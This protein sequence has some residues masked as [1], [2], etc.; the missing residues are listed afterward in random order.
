MLLRAPPVA[1]VILFDFLAPSLCR[2]ARAA[3]TASA[4]SSSRS[5][6]RSRPHSRLILHRA[7]APRLNYDPLQGINPDVFTDVTE[8]LIEK[9]PVIHYQASEPEKKADVFNAILHRLNIS[10]RDGDA[11]NVLRHWRDMAD[12]DLLP[13][14]SSNN[15]RQVSQ[16]ISTLISPS[17]ERSL[18][19]GIEDVAI[20]TA[21]SHFTD[22]LV[23]AM[24]YH[25]KHND[26]EAVISL[27]DR[28]KSLMVEKG[29]WE[30]GNAEQEEEEAPGDILPSVDDTAFRGASI[31]LPARIKVLLAA[32]VACA[33]R[34]DFQGALTTSL[35]TDVRFQFHTNMEFLSQLD[36]DS[37]LREKVAGYIRK[38]SLAKR[39]SHPL[40]FNFHVSRLG[41][42]KRLQDLLSDIVEGI[43]GRNAFIA[44]HP[45]LITESKPVSMTQ[46]G[47]ASFL[48]GF[49]HCKRK[50]LA[51]E[52]WERLPA[53]GVPHDVSM[54]TALISACAETWDPSEALGYW[55]LMRSKGVQPNALTHRALIIAYF[56]SKQPR[57]AIAHFHDF[58]TQCTRRKFSSDDVL[59]VY[60]AVINGQLKY[61]R[62]EDAKGTLRKLKGNGVTPSVETFNAF[63]IHFAARNDLHGIT[64]IMDEMSAAGVQGD[65]LTYSTILSALLKAGRTD[66]LDLV[67]GI[68]ESQG[69]EPST[70]TYTAIIKKQME[71][72]DEENFRGAL[73]L[74]KKMESDPQIQPTAETYLTFLRGLHR[75][76]LFSNDKVNKVTELIL[77]RMEQRD[78]KLESWGYTAM[79]RLW[80][81]G[82]QPGAARRA[83]KVYRDMVKK[84]PILFQTWYV[85]LSGL[86]RRGEWELADEVV[87]DMVDRIGEPEG[88]LKYLVNQVRQQRRG[89]QMRNL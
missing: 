63:L 42:V 49:Y 56:R 12:N 79:I 21:A 40:S 20:V 3:S 39:L 9:Q 2:P 50:D 14:L 68:M 45:Q 13:L 33:M 70:K 35:Q 7:N 69:I 1:S 15:L 5:I 37:A 72:E 57:L 10:L 29:I 11:T 76:K 30:G 31:Y 58:E 84:V 83:V 75:G 66:A 32:T 67:L 43:S 48:T 26:S 24:V 25:I 51:M 86:I 27:Y 55:D 22:A 87:G 53:L 16:L 73:N 54:W 81:D 19:D 34:D 71:Q 74:L 85:L 59:S 17:S 41:T 44:V 65:I 36:H 64:Y 62:A 28:Y 78:I 89:K 18:I 6:S 61:G 88:M 8:S 60:S 4:S 82:E 46:E 52:L 47:F 80:L 38:L 77:Q 23:N